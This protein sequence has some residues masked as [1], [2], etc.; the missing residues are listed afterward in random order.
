M[1]REKLSKKP[2]G[3]K[4]TCY[5]T[6][7][8]VLEGQMLVWIRCHVPTKHVQMGARISSAIIFDKLKCLE[9]GK[10][11]DLREIRQVVQIDTSLS[12]EAL[13]DTDL[14]S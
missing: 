1:L 6:K 9:L 2:N 12:I 10:H 4:Q 7:E 3:G 5:Q 14:L 11:N 13:Y 8:G